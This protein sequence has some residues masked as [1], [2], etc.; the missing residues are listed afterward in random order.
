MYVIAF[1]SFFY[2]LYLLSRN[3]AM[4]ASESLNAKSMTC[5]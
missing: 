2:A 4:K 3:M 5:H 1:L